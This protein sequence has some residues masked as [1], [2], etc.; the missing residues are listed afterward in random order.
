[1]N[2]WGKLIGTGVGMFG[3]PIGALAGAAIGHLYDEDDPTPQN[4]RKARILYLAY[5]FSCAAKISKADGGISSEEISMTELLMDRFGLDDKTKEFAKNVFR[6]AKNSKRSI[7][8]DFKEVA[9]LIGFEQTIAQSFVGGLFEIVKS[10][11][12]KVNELQIRFLL[13]A[14]ERF[15]L[16]PGTIQSW[17]KNGYKPPHE[18]NS[19]T[20]ISLEEAYEILMVNKDSSDSELKKAYHSKVANFHPDKLKSK[21]LPDEFMQFANAELAKINLAYETIQN[22]KVIRL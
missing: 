3:G 12:K 20:Q 2:W 4:E 19:A 7:D 6:K 22:T 8:D 9:K 5:F 18:E 15:K 11:G 21:N 13:R 10:N 1:M 14:E 16:Q 17:F